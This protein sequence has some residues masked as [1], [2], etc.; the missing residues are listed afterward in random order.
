M[1]ALYRIN[2]IAEVHE[3]Y[4]LGSPKYPLVSVI[5]ITDDIT[6]FDYGG[7]TYVS[8]LYHI[9]LK[10]GV[11]GSWSYGRNTYDF[12]DGTMTFIKPQQTTVVA[13]NEAHN[14]S[15]GWILLFHPD[16]IRKSTLV[17]KMEQYAFFSYDVTEA[18]HLSENEIESVNGL[19]Q[20]IETELGQHI[21]RHSQGLIIANIELL[22]NYCLRYYDRQF[23]TRTNINQ[24]YATRFER[25]LSD[26]F[27]SEKPNEL[28]VPTVK[29][30]GEALNM[31]PHYLSDLLRKE[32]GK[33][34]QEH[35]Y[36]HLIERAKNRL[37]SSSDPINQIAFSLGFDYS[38]HF[39]KIFK[40]KTG[41]TPAE[42][43]NLN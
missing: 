4:G 21:D 39:S 40:T 11:S 8:E 17:E 7:H 34:A 36:Y 26:Y 14:G 37:L 13:T 32:T 33:G 5:P 29:Y 30:C 28:G 6:N 16:L 31:S 20:K 19:I 9:S 1:T 12:Q 43:R 38:Q 41:M 42:Y 23:Y 27:D 24:D 15:H 35:I 10:L 2:S 18:L 25:L 22:L 3:F